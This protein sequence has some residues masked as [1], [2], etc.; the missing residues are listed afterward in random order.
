MY[1]TVCFVCHPVLCNNNDTTGI[2]VAVY[3]SLKRQ[4]HGDSRQC[5]RETVGDEFVSSSDNHVLNYSRLTADTH[6]HHHHHHHHSNTATA[7]A[8][9]LNSSHLDY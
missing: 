8:V 4:Q 5:G 3:R 1:C 7:A 6:Q 2:Y 9:G